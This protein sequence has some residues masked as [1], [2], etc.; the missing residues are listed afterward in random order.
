M[1]YMHILDTLPLPIHTWEDV[2]V[3]ALRL[4]SVLTNDL[5]GLWVVWHLHMM[6]MSKHQKQHHRV[7]M[8]FTVTS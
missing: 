5:Q 1:V 6:H 7:K 4:V 8:D 3:P 2:R